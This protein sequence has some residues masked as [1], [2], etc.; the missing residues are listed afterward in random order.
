MSSDEIYYYCATFALIVFLLTL[1]VWFF[2]GLL[3]LEDVYY[4]ANKSVSVKTVKPTTI[5]SIC[6]ELV[7]KDRCDDSEYP[8]HR[9]QRDAVREIIYKRGMAAVFKSIDIT[10]NWRR[11][12]IIR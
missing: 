12:G 8:L 6:R 7:L 9:L 10:S 4:F 1:A 5:G 11:D 2:R 3:E